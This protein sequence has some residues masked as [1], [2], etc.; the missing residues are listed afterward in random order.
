MSCERP[1]ETGSNQD[2]RTYSSDS[3]VPIEDTTPM[4]MVFGSNYLPLYGND[5]LLIK[6]NDFEVDIIPVTNGQFKKFVVAN[7][8]WRKGN[9]ARVFA[10]G[11]YLSDWESDT[12]FGT[13]NPNS[14]VT[15]VSWFAANAYA[16][17]VQKRLPTLDEWEYLALADD[18]V[19]DAR[20]MESYNNDILEWY[21]KHRTYKNKVG[22]TKANYW[23]VYDIHG[24]VWEWTYDFNSVMITGESR[25]DGSN[26]ERLFCGSASIG[27]AD[28]MN[29]A[30][31]IRYAFRGSLKANYCVRNL[32]FR[33]AKDVSKPI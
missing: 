13:L 17:S 26:D 21:E 1:D 2:S 12:S 32:G 20:I 5:T 27:A 9:L 33:C 10:D 18:S 6:V 15:N 22:Q 14:P 11:N 29:Y 28:K 31:F 23:N 16:Q 3:I 19:P 7:P 24:L 25:K 4:A 30:A 8:F